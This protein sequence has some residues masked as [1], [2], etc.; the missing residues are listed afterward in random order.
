[1]PN[2]AFRNYRPATSHPRPPA[3]G[4]HFGTRVHSNTPGVRSH[5]AARLTRFAWV[6]QALKN[7]S[8]FYVFWQTCLFACKSTQ[9]RYRSGC[10]GVGQTFPLHGRSRIC[11]RYRTSFRALKLDWATANR[12][13]RLYSSAPA[14]RHHIEDTRLR[15]TIDFISQKIQ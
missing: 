7:E 12:H 4:T 3:F 5:L 6:F 13:F 8:Q 9:D 2:A 11:S 10:T 15:F 1:M 14:T